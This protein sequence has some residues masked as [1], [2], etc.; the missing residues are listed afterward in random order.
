MTLPKPMTSS[1]KSDVRFGKQD[2]VYLPEKDAY[3]CLAG[4]QLPYSNVGCRPREPC[5]FRAYL[6]SK[7][8]QRSKTRRFVQDRDIQIIIV[9]FSA[10]SSLLSIESR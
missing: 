1:A 4:E 9:R 3:R 7:S 5:V 10:F 6:A 8:C 2:F